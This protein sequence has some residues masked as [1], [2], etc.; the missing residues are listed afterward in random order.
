MLS[1]VLALGVAISLLLANCGIVLHALSYDFVSVLEKQVFVLIGIAYDICIVGLLL[2]YLR[3]VVAVVFSFISLL[4]VACL[5]IPTMIKFYHDPDFS[6]LFIGLLGIIA[7]S[8]YCI[9][10]MRKLQAMS[11]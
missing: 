11:S 5:A 2:G 6:A 9:H 7:F 1:Y 3:K 4:L 8:S 10:F